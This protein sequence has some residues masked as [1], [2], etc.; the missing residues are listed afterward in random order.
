MPLETR[1]SVTAQRLL[2][3][4]LSLE[5]ALK[6]ENL[7]E[8]E[9]LLAD[10]QNTLYTLSTQML[11]SAAMAIL[12]KVQEAEFRVNEKM[13]AFKGELGEGASQGFRRRQQL[14]K[15]AG[16]GRDSAWEQVG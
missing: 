15:Y 16:P 6:S 2:L 10:R 8:V 1:A 7:E 4:T 13:L 5:E 14:R 3:L 11:D 9:S 12:E